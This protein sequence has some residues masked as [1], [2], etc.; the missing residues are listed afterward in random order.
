MWTDGAGVHTS[1]FLIHLSVTLLTLV[2]ALWAI[3]E[4]AR[5]REY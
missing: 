4:Q 5:T 2:F 3:R 1:V